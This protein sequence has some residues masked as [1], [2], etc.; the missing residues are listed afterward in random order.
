MDKYKIE[1][2]LYDVVDSVAELGILTSEGT[3]YI[4]YNIK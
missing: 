3:I 2:V 1:H 4:I